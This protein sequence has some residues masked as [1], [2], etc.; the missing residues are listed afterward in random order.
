MGGVNQYNFDIF[1][2]PLSPEL[3]LYQRRYSNK[4]LRRF[5]RGDATN[6]ALADILTICTFF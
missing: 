3:S 6:V 5:T 2:T 1:Q 4:I